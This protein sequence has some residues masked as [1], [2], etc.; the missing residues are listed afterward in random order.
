MRSGL[1]KVYSQELAS[2][3]H[4]RMLPNTPSVIDIGQ[5]HP[6][7]VD[8]APR[9]RDISVGDAAAASDPSRNGLR[10]N[11]AAPAHTE[12]V[13]CNAWARNN[14]GHLLRI[15]TPRQLTDTPVQHTFQGRLIE[16]VLD[17]PVKYQSPG[18]ARSHTP[19]ALTTQLPS[20]RGTEQGGCAWRPK[21]FGPQRAGGPRPQSR[22]SIGSST[23]LALAPLICGLPFAPRFP[24]VCCPGN[25]TVD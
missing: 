16:A 1:R 13:R 2:P 11:G 24:G 5:W 14:D 15:L 22:V 3:L 23:L 19:S 9:N 6:E 8:E 10:R 20:N 18:K 4:V 12:A 17:F 7:A 21:R 25:P